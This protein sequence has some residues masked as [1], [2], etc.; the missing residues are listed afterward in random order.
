[1]KHIH[2]LRNHRLILCLTIR[3]LIRICAEDSGNEA[4]FD[5]KKDDGFVAC[6]ASG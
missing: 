4:A 6:I 5:R 3:S 1:M 2:Q